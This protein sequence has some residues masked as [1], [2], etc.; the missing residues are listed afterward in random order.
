[1]KWLPEAWSSANPLRS[2]N[3]V[4]SRDL[5]AGSFGIF[6]VE[7]GNQ[8]FVV[9]W[10]GF[11]V[12]LQTLDIAG[13][14]VPCHFLG[15]GQRSPIG[16]AARQNWYHRRKPTFRFGPQYNIEMAVRFLHSPHLIGSVQAG[17]TFM[18][19]CLSKIE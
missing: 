17:Q 5:T 11:P 2:R 16:Y 13:N 14:G 12:F 8:R 1:M 6:E 4:I 15:F 10:N 7:R 18:E 19:R 3:R 9:R